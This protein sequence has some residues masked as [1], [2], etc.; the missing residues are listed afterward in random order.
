MT[1]S[2]NPG[3]PAGKTKTNQHGAPRVGDRGRT[4]PTARSGTNRATL[5]AV[6]RRRGHVVAVRSSVIGRGRVPGG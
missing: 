4:R 2:Q 1:K 3:E 5:R 6:P